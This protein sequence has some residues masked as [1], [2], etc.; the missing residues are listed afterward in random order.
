MKENRFCWSTPEG[1]DL[2]LLTCTPLSE[3]GVPHGFTSRW[4]SAEARRPFGARDRGASDRRELVRAVGLA[5]GVSMRQVHGNRVERIGPR[6]GD[7]PVCD[8]VTTRW[9]GLGLIVQ[10]ADCVPI[11]LWDEANDVVGAVHAG[12]RGTLARVAER[13]VSSLADAYGTQPR[14]LHAAIGPSIGG[15]CYEVGF[16]VQEVFVQEH[17]ET[18]TFFSTGPHG[19]PHLDLVAANR[20]Q[21]QRVGLSSERIH[22]SEICT[23]CRNEQ[24]YSYRKEGRGCGRLMGIIGVARSR[25]R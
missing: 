20:W 24:L 11:L 1:A 13:A 12:W 5:R 15:C 6:A 7:V 2:T 9:E 8:G 10:T 19:R 3:R 4:R 25:A 18:D 14:S 22:A 23:S 16:E 21:L 17:D